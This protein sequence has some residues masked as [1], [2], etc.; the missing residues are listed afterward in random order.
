MTGRETGPRLPDYRPVC[1]S[2]PGEKGPTRGRPECA[3]P[4]LRHE[5]AVQQGTTGCSWKSFW[6]ALE[7]WKLT[8]AGVPSWCCSQFI[9]QDAAQSLKAMM[10][11]GGNVSSW[12]N[13]RW[14]HKNIQ[15]CRGGPIAGVLIS[16]TSDTCTHKAD[17]QKE[18][19]VDTCRLSCQ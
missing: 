4:G 2:G 7:I 17:R 3:A 15:F 10:R 11:N 9:L 8:V 19:S 1:P 6:A 5:D 14:T 18:T 16:S 12:S 13:G